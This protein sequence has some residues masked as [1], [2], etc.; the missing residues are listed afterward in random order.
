MVTER[1]LDE[2]LL[3]GG[4]VRSSSEDDEEIALILLHVDLRFLL[5]RV[6]PSPSGGVGG[7]FLVVDL[8][9]ER[10]VGVLVTPLAEGGGTCC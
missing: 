7:D 1:E 10:L 4:G 3:E 9:V 2:F 8:L 6:K 5:T